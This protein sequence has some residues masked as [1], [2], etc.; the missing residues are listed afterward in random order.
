MS[1]FMSNHPAF[2][3]FCDDLIQHVLLV[4]E[5]LVQQVEAGN[6]PREATR[7]SRLVLSER[8]ADYESKLLANEWSPT[9]FLEASAH[10]FDT[11]RM[12]S[13]NEVADFEEEMR[14]ILGDD[15]TEEDEANEVQDDQTAQPPVIPPIVQ[16]P[17]NMV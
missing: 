1:R 6:Q 13:D 15:E 8:Q 7:R 5:T 10:L 3:K 12:P 14:E 17:P 2:W 11:L 9:K 16:L 4:S